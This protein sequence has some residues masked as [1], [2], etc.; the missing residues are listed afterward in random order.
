MN[1]RNQNSSLGKCESKP[2]L[3]NTRRNIMDTNTSSTRPAVNFE[4]WGKR[5]SNEIVT[6]VMT[7]AF[8]NSLTPATC[9]KM[10]FAAGHC[11]TKERITKF[12][13]GRTKFLMNKR[14][15]E[16]AVDDTD[17]ANQAIEEA[18]IEQEE[19]ITG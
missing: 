8:H 3:M 2:I 13:D 1:P 12:Y 16:A 5:T 17:L 11:I 18:L 4:A 10:L 9:S 7:T 14:A 19:A 6:E 15:I